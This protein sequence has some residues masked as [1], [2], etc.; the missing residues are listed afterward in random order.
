MTGNPASVSV[1]ALAGCLTCLGFLAAAGPARAERPGSPLPVTQA[2]L[3]FDFDIAVQPL[4]AA[5]DRYASI[6]GRP[7][8]FPSELVTERT[9]SAVQGRYSPEMAL[10][11]L[12]QG[13][14]LVVRQEEG[15]PAGAI[16]LAR[17][18]PSTRDPAPYAGID[19]LVGDLHF[20]GLLQRRI[21]EALCSDPGVGPG[22]YRALLRFELDASGR[23]HKVR[24]LGSTGDPR[25]DISVMKTLRTVQVGPPPADMLRQPLTMLIAPGAQ[26]GLARCHAGAS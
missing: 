22:A 17:V 5:L 12:L 14:G 20:P 4:A 3:Q 25:R 7:V 24:L 2:T 6:S 13:T 23:I 1:L 19:G 15:G 26:S 10:G 21:W 8:L 9:S 16:V 18:D 11:L